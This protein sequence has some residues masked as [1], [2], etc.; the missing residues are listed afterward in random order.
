MK[1]LLLILPLLIVGCATDTKLNVYSQPNGSKPIGCSL[2]IYRNPS[3][4]KKPYEITAS[5]SIADTGLTLIN[6]S[7]EKVM[8]T[9]RDNAC[10]V[11]ADAVLISN[12]RPPDIWSTCYRADASMLVFKES[13]S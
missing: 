4:I 2:E 13:E 5:I 9:I 3:F 11:G 12:K 10:E 7:R 1:R 6:C 8:K